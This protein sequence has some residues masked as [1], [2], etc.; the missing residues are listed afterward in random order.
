MFAGAALFALA[1]H[2]CAIAVAITYADGRVTSAWA[3]SHAELMVPMSGAWEHHAHAIDAEFRQ[4]DEKVHS[5][6]PGS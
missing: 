1:S 6:G 3:S 2:A 5:C 4:G